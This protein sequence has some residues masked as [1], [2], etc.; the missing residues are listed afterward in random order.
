MFYSV[1]IEQR[2]DIYQ[3]KKIWPRLELLLS[4]HIILH[5]INIFFFREI[6]TYFLWGK[7]ETSYSTVQYKVYQLLAHCRWF[8]PVLR[9]LPPL[10]LVVMIYICSWNIAESGVKHQISINQSIIIHE[11]DMMYMFINNSWI[12]GLGLGLLYLT[13][14]ACLLHVLYFIWKRIKRVM[15]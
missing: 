11:R 5:L 2:K 12:I 14:L 15:D 7:G 9:L 8:S 10:K 3:S 6:S 4:I 1:V 13:P